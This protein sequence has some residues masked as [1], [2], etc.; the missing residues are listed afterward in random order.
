MKTAIKLTYPPKKKKKTENV[1]KIINFYP[2]TQAKCSSNYEVL[3][4]NTKPL[5]SLAKL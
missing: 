5:M 3:K 2:N 4:A 1:A